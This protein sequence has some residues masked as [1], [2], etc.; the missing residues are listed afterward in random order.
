MTNQC[1]LVRTT[2]ADIQSFATNRQPATPA[3]RTF[4]GPPLFAWIDESGQA[5]RT[6]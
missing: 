1:D 2:N 5:R 3:P 6:K 4:N